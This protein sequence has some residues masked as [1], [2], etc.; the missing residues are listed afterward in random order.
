MKVVRNVDTASTEASTPSASSRTGRGAR[1]IAEALA[2]ASGKTTEEI[3]GL[4]TSG[5]GFGRIARDLGLKV[6]TI[7]SGRFVPPPPVT[8]PTDDASTG[9]EPVVDPAPTGEAP[10]IVDQTV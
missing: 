10:S 6:G 1:A 5:H 8:P 3:L 4:R 2:Q 7:R 9:G